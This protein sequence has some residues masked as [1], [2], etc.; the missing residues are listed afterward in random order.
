MTICPPQ[1]CHVYFFFLMIRRPPRSTQSRSSAASDVY[2]RQ[3]EYMGNIAKLNSSN[4][5]HGTMGNN[6]CGACGDTSQPG[7]STVVYQRPL[8][9]VMVSI[10]QG[11]IG[12]DISDVYVIAADTELNHRSTVSARVVK[13]SGAKLDEELK[14]IRTKNPSYEIGSIVT[15]SAG[16]LGAKFLAHAI[17][18]LWTGSNTEEETKLE[19]VVKGR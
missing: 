7:Y 18:P 2:K 3:A 19:G 6:N 15:T 11:D 4:K 16:E 13:K 14:E 17:I 1:Y 5:D 9:G 8:K 12:Q 10:V